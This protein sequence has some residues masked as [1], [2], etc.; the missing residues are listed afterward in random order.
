[1][2]SIFA[3]SMSSL[4]AGAISESLFRTRYVCAFQK[5]FAPLISVNINTGL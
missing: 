3:T 1:M 5:F 4:R 2:Q